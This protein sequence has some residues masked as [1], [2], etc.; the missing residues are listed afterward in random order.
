MQVLLSLMKIRTES[1]QTLK[2]VCSHVVCSHVVSPLLHTYNP[3]SHYQCTGGDK[4][5]YVVCVGSNG[6]Y[7]CNLER[8]GPCSMLH[9]DRD[10]SCWFASFSGIHIDCVPKWAWLQVGVVTSGS[11]ISGCGVGILMM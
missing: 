7:T 8:N 11:G 6:R 1:D 10:V 2:V 9:A 4:Y 5:T 3:Q